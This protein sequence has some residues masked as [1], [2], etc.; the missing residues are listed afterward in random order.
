MGSQIAYV[1]PAMLLWARKSANLEL[2]AA[3]RKLKLPVGKVDSWENG[4]SQ[5]TIAQL[6]RAAKLYNR[7]LGVFYLSEPP[8]GFETIRDFRR[9]NPFGTVEWS[10][11]LLTEFRRA[12]LQ[13]E[14]I[15]ELQELEDIISDARW[16][17]DE[18]FRDDYQLANSI[19][20][21]LSSINQMAMP[22]E[23]SNEFSHLGFWI[24]AIESAGVL[25]MCTTGG[26]VQTEEM[27]AFSLYFEE[28][29]VIVLNGADS[30]RGRLFSLIHEY[31]HLVI[32]TSGVCDMSTD[33][34]AVNVNRQ[35]EA[36][37]N[38]VAADVL[39]PAEIVLT[40][41][42]ISSHETGKQWV[43]EELIEGAKTFGVSAEAYLR[44]LVTLGLE[45][46]GNYELFRERS[47]T[48][49]SKPKSGSGN[50]YRTKARDLG[51]G[52]VRRVVGAHRSHLIDSST[53][54]EYLD[55]KVGQ[56]DQLAL[57]ARMN[58]TSGQ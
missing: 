13:R 29:P 46:V 8:A 40:Q 10:S 26:L 48:L 39:M 43:L 16:R 32:R 36:R 28:I 2:L 6:R 22:N 31:A 42:V 53:A 12:H 54:A 3:E 30:P 11:Q 23:F 14:T 56:I 47:S 1:E 52:Y 37:C 38:S 25:V 5:P 33:L 51:K 18:H 44:R 9:I 27:R 41:Q 20:E 50:F 21:K 7:T 35:I 45:N 58:S 55:V 34:R 57:S 19:R 24:S 4:Q 17:I 15:L 49:T